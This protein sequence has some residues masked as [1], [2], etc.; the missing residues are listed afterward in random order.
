MSSI[1]EYFAT[2]FSRIMLVPS[3]ASSL[4]CAAVGF[5]FG[6]VALATVLLL[7]VLEVTLSFDNAVVNAKVLEKM[8]PIW[9]HRFLTWGIVIAVFLTRAL[10]P[11]VIVSLSAWATPWAIASL[12]LF[13]ATHYAE[14]LEHAEYIIGAFGSMFLLMAGLHYFFDIDKRRHWIRPIE[15]HLATWGSVDAIELVV[16][17]VV[18]TAVGLALPL[19]TEEILVSGIIGIVL[20][21]IVQGIAKMFSDTAS[22]G[23]GLAL[24]AYLN[25]LDAAF[26][27]DSVVGAFALSKEIVIIVIGLGIG[28]YFVRTLT[29][30]MVEHG[31][32]GELVYLE[33]GAHWAILGL[34]AAMIAN[35]FVHI[36]DPIT[37]FIGLL[38]VGA[39]Y[40]S[41]IRIVEEPI[42][43]H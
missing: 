14:L 19:H 30:Y 17:L 42:T 11:I 6:W 21:A 12:A 1:A 39:A 36:P 25:V 28:A 15:R 35:L 41:S 27:L 40:I 10:L 3:L 9:R 33:H 38:F 34:A 37:G 22:M 2:P 13:D 29:I 24:F 8:S 5:W 7:V 31:T 43:T 32:L 4:L 16:A 26:S 20:F 23:S 18:L